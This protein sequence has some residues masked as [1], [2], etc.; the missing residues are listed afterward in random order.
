MRMI[1]VRVQR[2]LN[3]VDTLQHVLYL[4]SGPIAALKR[5]SAGRA[6]MNDKE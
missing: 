4:P 1:L 3:V 2:V 6:W 5:L